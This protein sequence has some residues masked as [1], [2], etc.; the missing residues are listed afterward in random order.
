MVNF[1]KSTGEVMNMSHIVKMLVYVNGINMKRNSGKFNW[2]MSALFINQNNYTLALFT[3]GNTTI[4]NLTYSRIIF[5]QTALQSTQLTYV[6]AGYVVALNTGWGS[7]SLSIPWKNTTNFMAGLNS[8]AYEAATAINFAY[9]EPTLTASGS[10]AFNN[11]T[12]CYFNYRYRACPS[13]FPFF[14]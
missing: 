1:T 4:S 3:S 11:L 5:D 2:T 7:L 12:I 14:N 6:D 8:L 10:M 13:G 9:N